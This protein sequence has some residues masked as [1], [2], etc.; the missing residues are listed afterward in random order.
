MGETMLRIQHKVMSTRF[1][2]PGR[3]EGVS[4]QKE[5]DIPEQKERAVVLTW[6]G[7]GKWRKGIAVHGKEKGKAVIVHRKGRWSY[8]AGRE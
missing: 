6:K 1:V 8:R 2:S 4:Y 5:G 3:G 7:N